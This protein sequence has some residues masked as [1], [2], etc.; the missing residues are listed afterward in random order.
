[1]KRKLS[2][3]PA[4]KSQNN[5]QFFPSTR[6]SSSW[7]LSNLVFPGMVFIAA[8]FLVSSL[9]QSDLLPKNNRLNL[10]KIELD[11]SLANQ[12]QLKGQ[13][14]APRYGLEDRL[15]SQGQEQVTII[16][17]DN[18]YQDGDRVT[19]SVNER[20]YATNHFLTNAGTE[21]PVSLKP[22]VNLV[23]IYGNRDGL[24][25]GMG[26]SLAADVSNRGNGTTSLMP[27]NATAMFN[28]IR[29]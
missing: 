29:P 2:N 7:D 11:P 22:G 17:R 19:L 3:S 9:G 14:E 18:G 4:H 25:N 5:G 6:S 20:V 23:K 12:S 13:T 8:L 1:M 27:E 26:I 24:Q 28:I 16:L 15:V 21:I 10:Q